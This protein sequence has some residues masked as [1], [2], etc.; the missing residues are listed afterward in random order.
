MSN[1]AHRLATG[2]AVLPVALILL[3][4]AAMILLFA[5]KNL[6][7]DLQITRNGY[8][9]RIA[10]A[11]ADS[12]LAVA[13]SKL[14]DPAQRK[15][16]LSET[17]GAGTYDTLATSELTQALGESVDVRIKFK[18]LSLGGSDL[19]LQVQST[20]CINDCKKGRAIVS[21]TI[22]MRGGIHQIPVALLSAR[23]S[24]AASGPVTLSN[25][26]PVVRGMLM[27]AGGGI[28][29]D[30]A[31]QRLSLPGQNPDLAEAAQD[32]G[33][34]QQSAD[35]FFARWFGADKDFIRSTATRV[36]CA[37]ECASS[38]AALGSRVI[39]L[40]GNARLSNGNLGSSAAPVIII[41]TG[42]LQLAGTLRLTGIVYS[43]APVTNIQ[44][45]S[46]SVEGA[47]IAEHALNV[48]QG[49][50]LVYNPVILQRAQSHLG[51][52]VPVPGSWSDGE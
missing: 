14:N 16:L 12:G 30:E 27:H 15:T 11:A 50:R 23:T 35:Q 21:Q 31:V 51:R 10:Y 33:Y 47:V 3:A 18:A 39:W 17:K 24:I 6:L 4:G 32:S 25:Q 20:G 29:R 45:G 37:G 22:A 28:N 34:A 48:S 19:R 44:L 41:A 52:F 26:S 36:T 13:L 43:M 46:G 5:Q 9:S 42:S 1:V 40:D 49:G 2:M 8:A 7:V 38:V